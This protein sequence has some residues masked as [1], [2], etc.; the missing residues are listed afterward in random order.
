MDHSPHVCERIDDGEANL[1][2]CKSHNLSHGLSSIKFH[3]QLKQ[4][5]L[6]I[7]I[8]TW[9]DGKKGADLLSLGCPHGRKL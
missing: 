8:P 7:Q 5:L 2:R 4:A 9:E 6:S 1:V 3:G